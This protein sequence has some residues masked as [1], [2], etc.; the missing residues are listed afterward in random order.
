MEKL[1]ILSMILLTSCTFSNKKEGEVVKDKNGN[2]YELTNDRCLGH[3]RYRLIP[4]DT[5]KFIR[6]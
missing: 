2:Y 1:I 5:T 6:F 4:I 3:E